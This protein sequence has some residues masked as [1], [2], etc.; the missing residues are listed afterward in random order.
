MLAVVGLFFCAVGGVWGTYT[1]LML[2]LA[3]GRME[4]W[5]FALIAGA[6]TWVCFA[7]A[8]RAA[9]LLAHIALGLTT[10]RLALR[11]FRNGIADQI[12]MMKTGFKD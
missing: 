10:P 2:T 4:A 1:L 3:L 5:A 8:R 6:A 9:T 7:T 11:D 12:F